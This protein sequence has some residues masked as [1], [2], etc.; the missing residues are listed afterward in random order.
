MDICMFLVR[1][2]SFIHYDTELSSSKLQNLQFL[3]SRL[4]LIVS[5]VFVARLTAVC[6]CA[7]NAFC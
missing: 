4:M 2:C 7:C 5:C 1:A 3:I 6:S